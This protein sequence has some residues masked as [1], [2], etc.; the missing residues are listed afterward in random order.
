V[1]Q[2]VKNEKKQRSSLIPQVSQVSLNL[3]SLESV[4][5]VLSVTLAC[6]DYSVVD[7]IELSC[8]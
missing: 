2:E 1:K 5:Y 4:P 7:G 3:F 6:A 8:Q